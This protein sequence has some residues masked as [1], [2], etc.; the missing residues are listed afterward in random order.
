MKGKNW[1][2]FWIFLLAGFGSCRKTDA[3]V[4]NSITPLQSLINTDTSFSLFHRMLLI[5][6]ET[7]MLADNPVTL[8]IPTNAAFRAAGYSE[9]YIDSLAPSVADRLVSYHFIPQIAQ[10]DSNGYSSYPTHLGYLLYGE[11]DS[12]KQVWFNG[13]PVIGD[14]IMAGKALVYTLNNI[15]LTPSDSLNHTLAQD[16]TL[17]FTAALFQRTG[18]DTALTPGFFTVLAPN[19]TAW[20]NAGYDSVGAIDSADFNTM[21]NLAKFHVLPGQY[22]SNQLA[23][24]NNVITLQG[25][26]LAVSVQNGVIQFKGNGNTVPANIL[27]ANQ[28]AGNTYVIHK[29]DQVL[30]P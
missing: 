12:G 22:F 6:N 15:L 2:V 30:S 24:L 29:I 25:G 3:P 18:L 16:S 8:L 10:P 21:L 28:P 13:A 5:A 26:S 17:S 20:I 27:T 14:T 1:W 9:R 7:G 23:G 4:Y 11:K 19:N